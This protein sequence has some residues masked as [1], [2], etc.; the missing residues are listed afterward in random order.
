MSEDIV[1][2]KGM[3]SGLQLFFDDA[4]DFAAIEENLKEKLESG[5]KFFY[6][7]T[8]IH[9]LPNSLGDE[10][11]SKLVQLFHQYGVFLRTFEPEKE[12]K[13]T[14][15]DK[16]KKADESL[17]VPAVTQEMTVIDRTLRGGQ[18][19]RSKGSVLI[20]GNINPGA[21]VIAG[22]SIDIR[23]TCR[24]IVHAGAYGNRKAFIIADRLMPV[25][26]RIA[27]LIAQAPDKMKK[28][29]CAERAS[30]KDGQIII[31]SMER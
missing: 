18:E 19:V 24:G 30:I 25:Q 21:Q 6:R 12:E 14:S 10:E 4:A 3:K 17:P 29:D 11:E 8:V 1:K 31:E 13:P 26:I 22:G 7:G 2:I 27:D 23:G 20:C 5:S 28:P 15:A 9:I 16:G